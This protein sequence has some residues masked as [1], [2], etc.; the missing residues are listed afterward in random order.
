MTSVK[1]VSQLAPSVLRIDS[2]ACLKRP[3]ANNVLLS[4]KQWQLYS[5]A[6][7]EHTGARKFRGCAQSSRYWAHLQFCCR[8]SRHCPRS[9]CPR[10][11]CARS[12]SSCVCVVSFLTHRALVLP[13]SR[14]EQCS[15][16]QQRNLFIHCPP[17]TDKKKLWHR[18]WWWCTSRHQPCM[19]SC[20]RADRAARLQDKWISTLLDFLTS[21]L[22]LALSK[23]LVSLCLFVC[24]ETF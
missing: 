1:N 8:A 16:S 2:V 11:Q 7:T 9:L 15:R 6:M 23:F 12:H 21:V 22:L 4:L 13:A 17:N 10:S 19:R 3:F 20:T 14:P 18:D 5:T 24:L